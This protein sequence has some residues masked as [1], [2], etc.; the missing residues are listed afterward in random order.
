MTQSASAA[1]EYAGFL[2]TFSVENS[3]N[4]TQKST[5]IRNRRWLCIYMLL[6]R[7][8]PVLKSMT[9]YARRFVDEIFAHNKNEILMNVLRRTRAKG[10][11]LNRTQQS[12]K[13]RKERIREPK[14]ADESPYIYAGFV[15]FSGTLRKETRSLTQETLHLPIL[16]GID[17][18]PILSIS[19]YVFSGSA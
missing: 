5:R 1:C 19:I 14:L 13:D 4:K 18:K 12:L 17:L 11:I 10:Y 9:R 8:L 7:E 15:V 16:N 2:L 6:R 3:L